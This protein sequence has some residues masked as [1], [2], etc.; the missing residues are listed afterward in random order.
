MQT[1]RTVENGP[2]AVLVE[3]VFRAAD[4]AAGSL[5]YRLATGQGLVELRCGE[6]ARQAWVDTAAAWAVVP[7]F[8]GDDAV[9]GPAS[10][11][12]SRVGVPAENFFLTLA[13]QGRAMLMCVWPAAPQRAELTLA[14]GPPRAITGFTIDLPEKAD[15]ALWLAFL[16]GQDLWQE[17]SLGPHARNVMLDWKPAFPAKWRGDFLGRRALAASWNLPGSA[18]DDAEAEPAAPGC[19][20]RVEG[21]QL[22]L[23][24]TLAQ[25][26]PERLLLYPIDRSRATPLTVFCPIDIL[27]N[28]L[29]VGPCQ[30]ILQTEGLASEA[31]P[32]PDSVMKWVEQQFHKKKEKRA[33]DEIRSLLEQMAEHVGHAQQRVARYAAVAG[34][35]RAM[36]PA[37][38]PMRDSVDYLERA[39]GAA[40]RED[41]HTKAKQLGSQVVSL[42]GHEGAA[43]ECRRLG[44]EIRRLGTTQDAALARARMALRWLR[45]QARQAGDDKI[46]ARVTEI[47]QGH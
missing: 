47:L 29:G 8:F 2:S 27:R 12:A 19:P 40:A 38:S 34:P 4:G 43:V 42:I 32:T 21:E 5:K 46:A 28:T 15:Q 9:L 1:F 7:D 22:R 13:D 33:A 24:L 39:V 16:E 26:P 25:S 20:C 31:T 37:A 35:L 18:A 41:A 11:T 10:L 30:Y 44:V 23:E 17:R 3:A 6:R 36:L 45:A 14:D